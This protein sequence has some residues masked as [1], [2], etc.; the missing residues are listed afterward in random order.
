MHQ[1]APASSPSLFASDCDESEQSEIVRI[2]IGVTL[3]YPEGY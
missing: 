3:E 1:V 2:Y